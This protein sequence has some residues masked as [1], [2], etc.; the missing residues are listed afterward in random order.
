M[1]YTTSF[2]GVDCSIDSASFTVQG[3]SQ[4]ER[5]IGA[6]TCPRT[7]CTGGIAD[8][9]YNRVFS[10]AL[11]DQEFLVRAVIVFFVIVVIAGAIIAARS[12]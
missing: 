10:R 3:K 7:S 9:L 12:G 5:F 1:S 2:G 4:H 11:F 8:Q 6:C